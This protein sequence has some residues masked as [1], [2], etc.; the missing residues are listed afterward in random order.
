MFP[1]N[2]IHFIYYKIIANARLYCIACYY[3]ITFIVFNFYSYLHQVLMIS[4]HMG[5]GQI[6][7]AHRL[8][9]P[10][11]LRLLHHEFSI[12]SPLA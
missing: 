5:Y 4:L 8:L 11:A 12:P 9:S 10:L 3:L 1:I 2:Y 6:G 7:L